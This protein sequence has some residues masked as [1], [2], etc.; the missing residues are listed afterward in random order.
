MHTN[1]GLIQFRE[2]ERERIRTHRNQVGTRTYLQKECKLFVDE[3]ERER[4]ECEGGSWRKT[5]CL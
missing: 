1:L 2:R 4:E 3:R 5:D